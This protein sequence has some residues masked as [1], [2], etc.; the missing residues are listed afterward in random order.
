MA[1]QKN[2]QQPQSDK[3]RRNNAMRQARVNEQDRAASETRSEA[4]RRREDGVVRKPR[5]LS[6]YQFKVTGLV[7][8][9]LGTLN[10]ALIMPHLDTKNMSDLTISVILDFVS[11]LAIPLYAWAV[12]MGVHHSAHLGR[13][14]ARVVLL[15]ALS[16]VPYD[17]ATTQKFL[18]WHNNNP[19]WAVA[20]CIVVLTVMRAVEA[21]PV[22]DSYSGP[23]YHLAPAEANVVRAVVILAAALWMFFGHFGMRLGMMNEGLVLLMFVVVFELLHRHENTMTYTAAMLGAFM[24][25]TPGLGMAVVHYHND[26]L[27]Y[28]SPVTKYLFYVLYWAQ[29]AILGAGAMLA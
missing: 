10:T 15:A 16:E 7:F 8:V 11:W 12:L 6:M 25:L 2:F 19:V 24:G 17:M 18:D 22:R 5:G 21:N 26:Q 9:I 1:S 4:Y 20:I 28:R 13:Y 14:L 23:V 3:A 29:L 27:G